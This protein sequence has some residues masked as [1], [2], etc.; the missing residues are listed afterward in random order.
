MRRQENKDRAYYENTHKISRL[1][2][3]IEQMYIELESTYNNNGLIELENQLEEAKKSLRAK[4]DE[5]KAMFKLRK[6]Q[7]KHLRKHE[8]KSSEVRGRV[9]NVAA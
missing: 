2:R 5:A 3:E 6:T 8:S 7:D 1:K 4:H 9:S